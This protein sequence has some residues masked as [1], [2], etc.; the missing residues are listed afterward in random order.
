MGIA[1]R[2]HT[3]LKPVFPWVAL[4]A[5]F[6]A[7][8]VAVCLVVSVRF[9]AGQ[10]QASMP[11]LAFA[12]GY[13]AA[14]IGFLFTMLALRQRCGEEPAVDGKTVLFV[15]LVGLGLRAVLIAS[16][17]VLE[18]DFNRYLWDG[19]MT[20]RGFNPFAI[21]P[22]DIA[23]LPYD[24]LRVELSK[25]A[26]PVFDGISYP[27]LK[28]IYP[29]VAQAAFALAYWVAPFE[30]WAWRLVAIAADTATFW[31]LIALLAAAGRSAL[32]SVLYWWSPLV[33]KE[34]AN[35]GHMEAIVLPLVLAS[36]LLS[37]RGRHLGAVL[38]L[39][40][41]AGAKLWPIMLAPIL[42]RPLL[43]RPQA[44]A[45]AMTMLA[46]LLSLFAWPAYLGGIDTS[47]GFVAFANHWTTNSALFPAMERMAAGIA[48]AEP[49]N[50]MPGRVLR[51]ASAAMV[52]GLAV[53]LSRG[54]AK[55]AN[56]TIGRAFIVTSVLVLASPAQFPW[57]VLWVLPLAALVRG[58]GWHVAA[59]LMPIYYIAF[60]FIVIDQP[61]IYS[62]FI[63]WLLWIPIWIALVVDGWRCASRH[64]GG[65]SCSGSGIC[66]P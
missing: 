62:S 49:D 11:I 34:I 30:L 22:A 5:A 31:L 50:V 28:S 58:T 64:E 35:S 15:F 44:L 53:W 19:A 57:Y 32:W 56:D 16:E 38:M 9:A 65:R 14:G 26:G 60:H 42:L 17:P 33:L 1:E 29:P 21:A 25:V 47:S 24:D 37:I 63:V 36:L 39:G 2:R 48:G 23:L 13:L 66:V 43:A 55:T 54:P 40:L 61:Q 45:A 18:V 46:A 4:L 52:L 8:A 6:L 12:A 7:V 20:A 51:L 10:P 3:Q 27:E 41:A 59:A